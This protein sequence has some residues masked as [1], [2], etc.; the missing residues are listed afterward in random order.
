MLFRSFQ[1]IIED[2][3]DR[4]GDKVKGFFEELAGVY[5]YYYNTKATED[6]ANKMDSNLRGLTFDNILKNIEF[7]FEISK[8]F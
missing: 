8:L 6:E 3:N 7:H 2:L 4:W 5:G 1:D